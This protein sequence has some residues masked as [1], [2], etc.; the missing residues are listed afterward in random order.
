MAC[1][2]VLS[3]FP[4]KEGGGSLG[5]TTISFDDS[6]SQVVDNID[7]MISK[8]GG[9]LSV[10]PGN[11]ETCRYLKNDL[12]PTIKNQTWYILAK[13]KRELQG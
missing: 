3:L 2:L 13:K 4:P 6:W 10:V 8:F 1:T 12:I 9:I 11:D 7:W 5:K